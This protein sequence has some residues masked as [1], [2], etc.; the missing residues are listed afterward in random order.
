MK[1]NK[2]RITATRTM[3]VACGLLI[4]LFGCSSKEKGPLPFQIVFTSLY[5]NESAVSEYGAI[6]LNDIPELSIDGKAPLFTSM[7][8]GETSNNP[9]SGNFADPMMAMGSIMRLTTLIA[10]GDIDIIISDLDNAARN[11]RGGLFLSLSDVCTDDDLAALGDRLLSFDI[12]RNDGYEP[13]PTGEKTPICGINITGNERIRRI[14]GNQE[15]GVFIVANTKNLELAR[16]VMVSL[17]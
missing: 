9:E 15:I 17:L 2:K 3:L 14:F 5:I 6:L 12:L 8:M 10:N 11:A 1:T 7:I 13:T 16:R 4:C